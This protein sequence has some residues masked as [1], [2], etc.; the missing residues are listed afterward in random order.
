MAYAIEYFH[1]VVQ[2]EITSWPDSILASYAHILELL[3][4]FGP[5]LGM[6][7]FTRHGGGTL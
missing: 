2:A 3:V 1:P 7:V 4:D 5:Q 6:R